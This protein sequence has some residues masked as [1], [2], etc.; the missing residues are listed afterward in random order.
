MV[1]FRARFVHNKSIPA[2][3]FPAEGFPVRRNLT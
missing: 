2:H 3:G 1:A